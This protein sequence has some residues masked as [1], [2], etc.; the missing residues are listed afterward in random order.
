MVVGEAG[1]GVAERR[2]ER[3]AGNWGVKSVP[4]ATGQRG[5]EVARAGQTGRPAATTARPPPPPSPTRAARR[6]A[7]RPRRG[8]P[9]RH[10][11]RVAQRRARDGAP[12]PLP[13]AATLIKR[14]DG[15]GPRGERWG[16]GAGKPRARR[17][18]APRP[19]RHSA[20]AGSA[21]VSTRSRWKLTPPLPASVP[22]RPPRS[23][24]PAASRPYTP[25]GGGAQA[26]PPQRAGCGPSLPRAPAPPPAAA[27]AVRAGEAPK[28]A[29]AARWRRRRPSPPP[30]RH[31]SAGGTV[32]QSSPFPLPHPPTPLP[33][34]YGDAHCDRT[35][36]TA[37]LQRRRAGVAAG[38]LHHP[39]LGVL[40]RPPRR[41]AAGGG[42][43]PPSARP[44]QR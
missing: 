15:R 22:A 4:W 28:A 42:H 14:R 26:S 17:H 2:L 16:G 9:R 40:R 39:P 44:P 38:T 34:P 5:R 32:Q 20:R 37:R 21:R 31:T 41:G 24:L 30:G 11:R 29:A 8:R 25:G 1:S 35:P 3:A 23:P 12:L 7:G 6:G 18:P 10:R 13:P 19:R 36:R 43:P 33:R 27:T